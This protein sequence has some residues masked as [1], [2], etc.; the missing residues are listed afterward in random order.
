M[1]VVGVNVKSRAEWESTNPILPLNEPGLELDR[2][3]LKVGDGV[4]TWSQLPTTLLSQ[5]ITLLVQDNS[6]SFINDGSIL[7][8]GGA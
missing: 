3:R 5:K 4:R 8:G 2:V 1:I 6:E 7:D